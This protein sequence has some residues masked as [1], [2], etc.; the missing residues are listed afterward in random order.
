MYDACVCHIQD[1]YIADEVKDKSN[2][3][4]D[5]SS[6]KE[7]SLDYVPLQQNGYALF[8]PLSISCLNSISWETLA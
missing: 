1:K 7:A 2:K 5:I 4:I 6:W 3:E 8:T